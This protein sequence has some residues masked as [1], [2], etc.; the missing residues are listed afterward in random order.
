MSAA[1]SAFRAVFDVVALDAVVADVSVV[2]AVLLDAAPDAVEALA[3]AAPPFMA[4]VSAD[5]SLVSSDRPVFRLASRAARPD[6]APPA[7]AAPLAPPVSVVV[8]VVLD[9]EEE[10]AWL[11]S[12][13]DKVLLENWE[14][15]ADGGGGGGGASAA[16]E[17]LSA[18]L[19][20]APCTSAPADVAAVPAAPAIAFR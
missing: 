2:E 12:R 9:A 5:I 13:A 7:A 19:A 20:V 14:D 11:D 17:A 3:V 1:I 6:A 15:A 18:G 8:A 4:L 10:A 16:G